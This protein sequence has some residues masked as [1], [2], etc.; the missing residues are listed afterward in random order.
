MPLKVA[1]V[2]FEPAFAGLGSAVLPGRR[3]GKELLSGHAIVL[4][5]RLGKLVL[6]AC[7]NKFMR[8]F[9]HGRLVDAA[10]FEPADY[11]FGGRCN[12]VLLRAWS[13]W[14][15]SNRLET[16]AHRLPASSAS[17]TPWSVVAVAVAGICGFHGFLCHGMGT[18]RK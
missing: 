17:C 12:T 15:G 14:P 6:P 2:G 4:V 13:L 8:L 5:I 18:E 11:G 7:D 9:V 3:W 1:P 10:G 16:H